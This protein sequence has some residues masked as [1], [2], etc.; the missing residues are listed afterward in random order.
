M[1]FNGCINFFFSLSIKIFAFT[2]HFG[3]KGYKPYL[4]RM[5]GIEKKNEVVI[6]WV[7]QNYF[8]FVHSFQW[9]QVWEIASAAS[10]W[11]GGKNF[12]LK[13]IQKFLINN[14]R[15]TEVQMWS[16]KSEKK[17]IENLHLEIRIDCCLVERINILMKEGET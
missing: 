7:T 10:S 6:F 1:D 3:I 12:N 9:D 11:L 8:K 17:R 13:M 5:W 14:R 15:K 4:D 2:L 16:Y